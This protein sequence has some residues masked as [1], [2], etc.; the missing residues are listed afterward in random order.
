[1]SLIYVTKEYK[2]HSK[3]CTCWNEY[4]QE[5]DVVTKYK[6]TRVKSFDGNENERIMMREKMD[7]WRLVIPLCQ[8]GLKSIYNK[9]YVNRT[10]FESSIL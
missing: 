3:K 5:G 1:M 9:E 6:C 4:E 8:N 7:S 2:G 10:V